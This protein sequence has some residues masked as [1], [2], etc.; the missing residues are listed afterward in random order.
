MALGSMQITSI[1]R[2][3][4]YTTIK[5]NEDNKSFTDQMNIGQSLQKDTQQKTREVHSS[6]NADWHNRQFDAREKGDNE[7]EGDGGQRRKHE[8]KKERVVVNGHQSFDI[9]I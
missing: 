6:D 9:K 4:D 1:T 3:H 8:D 7:Y 2:S 5:Q